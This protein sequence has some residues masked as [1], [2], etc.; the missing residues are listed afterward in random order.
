M[1]KY[2]KGSS[3]SIQVEKSEAPKMVTA[4]PLDKLDCKIFVAMIRRSL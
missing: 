4:N 1:E 3:E 2:L